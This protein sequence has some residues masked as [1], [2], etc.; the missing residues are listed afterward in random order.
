MWRAIGPVAV[1]VTAIMAPGTARAWDT[2]HAPLSA[3]GPKVHG[4]RAKTWVF[5]WSEGLASAIDQR[6]LEGLRAS[7]PPQGKA[8]LASVQPELMRAINRWRAEFPATGAWLVLAEPERACAALHAGGGWRSVHSAKGA[9][10]DVLERE[11]HR[12]EGAVPELV[13]LAGA[14][15]PRA[16]A[17]S[18]GAWKFRELPA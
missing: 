18:A 1:A 2:C 16:E 6:L 12:V 5:R 8:R 13:L 7:F 15:A 17:S 3:K 10:L 9:W 11:R 14:A 4:E